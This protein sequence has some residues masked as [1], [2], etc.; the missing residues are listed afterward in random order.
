MPPTVHI[1][2][3]EDEACRAAAG[4]L[5]RK[6]A[7]KPDLV[8][9]L[10]T[11]QT[12]RGLYRELIRHHR[13]GQAD[14]SRV[15][16]FNIDEYCGLAA[17]DPGSFRRF[18]REEFFDHINVPAENIHFPRAVPADAVEA[19]RSYEEIVAAA[20]GI[21]VMIL[22]V[23]IDGH[24]GFNMP[25]SP[26]DSRTRL[27]R[28]NAATRAEN[29]AFFPPGVDVPLHAVTMGLGTIMDSRCCLLLAFGQRKTAI[30]ARAVQGPVTVG[31]P[32]SLL[33]HHPDTV[34]FLD[35]AASLQLRQQD[36][37]DSPE[38]TGRPAS[39]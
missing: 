32:A 25:G 27:V 21:D 33:Q 7:E 9:G 3:T 19:S 1:H 39:S 4:F 23:G 14:F 17:T 29:A 28:I 5:L 13:A 24:L 11:G 35:Q 6:L 26:L 36:S 20:G 34:V 12:P 16:T 31:L 30:L 8:L 37:S 15:K 22:G 10:P 2:E 38:C 18:M